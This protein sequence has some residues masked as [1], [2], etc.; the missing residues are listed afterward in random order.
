MSPPISSTVKD[1]VIQLSKEGM[2]RD[3][4]IKELGIQGI[5]I[6]AGSVSNILKAHRQQQQQQQ[7]HH[8]DSAANSQ[9]VNLQQRATKVLTTGEKYPR[10]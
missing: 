10:S 4:I 1:R 6:S 8:G 5:R 7:Q 9:P 3:D 2:Y